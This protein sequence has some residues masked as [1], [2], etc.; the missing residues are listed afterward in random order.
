[1]QVQGVINDKYIR[2]FNKTNLSDGLL[3]IVNI[4]ANPPSL[5]EKLKLI[6]KLCGSWKNDSSIESVFAEIG[7]QRHKNK[8][9][10]VI[11]DAAS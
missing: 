2:L 5:E 10:E 4:K 8:S 11:F 1:M 3:V 7:N 9:R 6:D